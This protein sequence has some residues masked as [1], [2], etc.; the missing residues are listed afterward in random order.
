M[1]NH[2]EEKVEGILAEILQGKDIEL[3]D[4]EYVKERDWYLRVYLDKSGGIEID[5]CQ[6]ISQALET[7]LDE[8]DFIGDPYI[9]EVSSPGLDRVL[10]KPRDFIRE[11]GKRVDVSLYAPI[12]GEKLFVATLDG[13]DGEKDEVVFTDRGPLPRKAI[14]QIRLHMDF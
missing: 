1:V 5:D 10:K 11:K 4:V 2:V 13:L 14:A 6:R 7:V 3:V 8:R 9:L 12:D